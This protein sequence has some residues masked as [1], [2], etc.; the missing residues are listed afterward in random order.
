MGVEI[1]EDCMVT[2]FPIYLKYCRYQFFEIIHI[3]NEE[4]KNLVDL[5]LNIC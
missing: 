5:L 4:V 1:L 2:S 3:S